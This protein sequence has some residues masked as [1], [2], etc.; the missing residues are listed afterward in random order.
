[1]CVNI[2]VIYIINKYKSYVFV[3]V[4]VVVV[5]YY[6]N[7]NFFIDND[8]DDGENTR[9]NVVNTL[10]NTMS[11]NNNTMSNNKTVNNNN[12]NNNNEI[13][14]MD[15]V[16]DKHVSIDS[17][18]GFNKKIMLLSNRN[19]NNKDDNIDNDIDLNTIYLNNKSIL[20]SVVTFDIAYKSS[21]LFKYADKELTLTRSISLLSI[22]GYKMQQVHNHR[23]NG[24]A[25]NEMSYDPCV[26][27]KLSPVH[28]QSVFQCPI[29]KMTIHLVPDKRIF[30]NCFT[31]K[32]EA[33]DPV[34]GITWRDIF[35][36]IRR[37][38][39]TSTDIDT[40]MVRSEAPDFLQTLHLPLGSSLYKYGF[41]DTFI[42]SFTIDSFNEL[43]ID[44]C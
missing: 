34:I 42:H 15:I 16:S 19:N 22:I 11:N 21:N 23:D 27:T 38:F 40:Y 10:S 3:F 33:N 29:D 41:Y 43:C 44:M 37:F 7:M 9:M 17:R 1:M 28:D 18:S 26:R 30:K 14:A 6:L 13:K 31:I 39:I 2:K 24:N 4:V 36:T 20:S 8:E 35:D 12:S 5:V 32:V 25:V